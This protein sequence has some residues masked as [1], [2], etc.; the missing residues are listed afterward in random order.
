MEHDLVYTLSVIQQKLLGKKQYELLQVKAE[1][2]AL[3]KRISQSCSYFYDPDI[4]TILRILET[5]FRC[6]NATH[7]HHF[8]SRMLLAIDPHYRP[9]SC[10]LMQDTLI[11]VLA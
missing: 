5:L 4:S 1:I 11:H 7:L 8:V 2:H 10:C 3:I 6:N 9:L